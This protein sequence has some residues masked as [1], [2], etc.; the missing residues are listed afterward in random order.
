V[1]TLFY[2]LRHGRTEGNEADIYRGW[3]N[4]QFAQLAPEGRDDVREAA[5]FLKRA[6]LSFP[7]VISDDLSRSKES[8][9]IA[10]DILGV[11]QKEIDKRARPL[12]VGDFTGQPKKDHPLEEY[13]KNRSKKIPGGENMNTFDNRLAKFTGDVL[14]LVGKI[15]KPI[16][17]IGHGSTISFLYNATQKGAE[18]GYEGILHPGGI[19]AFTDEGVIRLF[20]PKFGDGEKPPLSDGTAFSGFV[21][22]EENRPP[23]SCWNCRNFSKDIAGLGSCTHP[24]V[25]IDPQLQDR[26]QSDNSIAVGD[27]DCCNNF[28]NKLGT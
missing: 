10:A 26:R 18:A 14:E 4:E 1:K 7:L 8:A 22:Q 12:N 17:L 2:V 5:I 11:K 20:K 27:E 6:G 25:Q 9:Q 24:L 28:R 3:S 16:L 23:R 15:K 21:T 13:M 19:I